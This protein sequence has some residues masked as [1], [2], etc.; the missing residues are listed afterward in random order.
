MKR[1]DYQKLKEALVPNDPSDDGYSIQIVDRCLQCGNFV[2]L[3]S[4][5]RFGV[6]VAMNKKCAECG[7]DRATMNFMV[8][9]VGSEEQFRH[10]W[11]ND[12]EEGM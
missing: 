9:P 12:S 4:K 8:V 10:A 11:A 1:V 7:G 6:K 3:R 5:Q 2:A